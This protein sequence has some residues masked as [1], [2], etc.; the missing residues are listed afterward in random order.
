MEE[1]GKE[2]KQEKGNHTTCRNGPFTLNS[3]S[4]GILGRACKHLPRAFIRKQHPH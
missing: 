3:Y 1:G 4:L 2:G